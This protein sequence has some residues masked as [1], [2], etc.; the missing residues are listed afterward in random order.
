MV[1]KK[2]LTALV[3]G[4][5]IWG[6]QISGDSSSI[7][8]LGTQAE[9]K[10]SL[11]TADREMKKE[12]DYEP[13][14]I[15]NKAHHIIYPHGRVAKDQRTRIAVVINGDEQVVVEDRVK[16]RI[17]SKL[18]QKFS[19]EDF[20]LMKGTDIK[21][22]LLQTEEDRFYDSRPSSTISTNRQP[23]RSSNGFSV[24]SLTGTI[25]GIKYARNTDRSVAEGALVG[26]VADNLINQAMHGAKQENSTTTTMQSKTDVDHMPVGIQP[27]G[28]SDLRR[29]DFVQAGRKYGYDYVFVVTMNVGLL[30]HEKHGYILFDS[31]TN[32]GN[33]WVRVRLVDVNSGDYA[34]RNDIVTAG[35]TH[36]TRFSGGGV[37]GRLMEKAVDQAMTE[38]MNDIAIEVK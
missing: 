30:K 17:Y 18:R 13:S 3:V 36:G 25:A 35:V 34:Y 29:E 28:F 20:A 6:G 31:T 12:K 2:V 32:K 15:Y 23:Y 38:A 27:R 37:N 24:G 1:K 4:A 33:I 22:W 7:I 26:A 8:S 21:T 14:D 5:C 10:A 11:S 16:N 9:A 19:I